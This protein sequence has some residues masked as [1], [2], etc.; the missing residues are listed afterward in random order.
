MLLAAWLR[1]TRTP[2]TLQSKPST[3]YRT[4]MPMLHR[5]EL[6]R[7]SVLDDIALLLRF[8]RAQ[9]G[10]RAPTCLSADGR[11]PTCILSQAACIISRLRAV[12]SCS[13]ATQNRDCPFF[14]ASDVSQECLSAASRCPHKQAS[15]GL[16]LLYHRLTYFEYMVLLYHRYW[17]TIGTPVP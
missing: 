5:F 11:L 4:S 16:L 14:K 2:P 7:S 3:R 6:R 13:L 1:W 15:G 12:R 8:K 10:R 17:C 9:G